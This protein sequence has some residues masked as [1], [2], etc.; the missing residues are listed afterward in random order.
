MNFG[1]FMNKSVRCKVCAARI[2]QSAQKC[3]KCHS[4]QDWRRYLAFSS[5]VLALLVAL[6][7]V[8]SFAVPV[9]REAFLAKNSKIDVQF[10]QN[11][12]SNVYLILANSG[13]R[14]GAIG[15]VKM[16]VTVGRQPYHFP[17]VSLGGPEVVDPASLFVAAGKSKYL[18]L[19]PAR[20]Y[21]EM[22]SRRSAIF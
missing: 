7:S 3:T 20:G 12:R 11:I 17:L 21:K 1:G 15:E 18:K 8:L 16:V 10:H 14:P 2:N 6:A 9:W 22:F 13:Q 5:S 4:Y 19:Y